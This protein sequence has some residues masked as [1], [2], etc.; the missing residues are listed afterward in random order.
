MREERIMKVVDKKP[1]PLYEVECHECKSRIR[2]KKSEVHYTGYITCP[3]CGLSLW[4][5]TILPVKFGEEDDD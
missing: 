1:V 3:V 4:A 5:S 2:Y